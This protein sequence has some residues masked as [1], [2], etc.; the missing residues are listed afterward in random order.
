MR[1]EN[2][3]LLEMWTKQK[4]DYY[5][6]ART[7]WENNQMQMAALMCAYAIEAQIKSAFSL[8]QHNCPIKELNKHN[9]PKLFAQAK[10]DGIFSD[11]SVSGEFLEFVMDNFERR[12]PKQ[13]RDRL[14]EIRPQGRAFILISD[15]NLYYDKFIIDLDTSIYKKSNDC[16]TSILFLA[17]R[18]LESVEGKYFF[19]L[20]PAA[21]A[22]L[23]EAI[24]WLGEELSGYE[25]DQEFSASYPVHVSIRKN[26]MEILKRMNCEWLNRDRHAISTLNII[27]D[28]ANFKHP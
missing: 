24:S 7:L 23:E 22:R 28:P 8:F 16:R 1:N 13:T 12:Y 19:Q 3:G 9:V 15:L 17:K 11:V 20:N 18:N 6:A 14:Q 26:E 27:V 5:V 2:D 25:K 10:N 21:L 4:Y